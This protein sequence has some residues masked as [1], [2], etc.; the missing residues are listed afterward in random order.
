MSRATGI[1]NRHANEAVS[2]HHDRVVRTS[3]CMQEVYDTA[4]RI[5]RSPYRWF[6]RGQ[7]IMSKEPPKG[8]KRDAALNGVFH[9]NATTTSPDHPGG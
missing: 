4:Q 8:R 6:C 2:P 5:V 9:C 1:G 7:P 3:A